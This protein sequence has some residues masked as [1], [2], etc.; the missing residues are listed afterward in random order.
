MRKQLNRESK[1]L[2]RPLFT[3]VATGAS[4]DFL[5]HTEMKKVARYV[6]TVDLMSYDY[7]EPTD[8]KTT[9]HHAPL[10]TNEAD[11]K[12]VSAHASVNNYLAAGVPPRK[13]VL[14]VPFYGH[15]WSNVANT[16]HGLFQPAQKSDL[17]ANY[18]EIVQTYLKNGFV[19]YWDE[20]A[21]GPTST[22]PQ[23]TPSSLTKTSNQ[24]VSNANTC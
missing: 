6:D 11:P 10:F 21:S 22:T 20:A 18:S 5:A 14:G 8:D 2:G 9:G 24:Y 15:A 4:P 13:L 19:R 12:R 17:D 3:S 16:N 1:K 23:T 7:Y